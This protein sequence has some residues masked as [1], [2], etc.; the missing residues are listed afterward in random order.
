MNEITVDE[1]AAP[2]S[3][4]L[5]HAQAGERVTITREGRPVACL[6]PLEPSSPREHVSEAVRA[7]RKLR[8]GNR[9]GRLSFR[10]L[11]EE[12]RR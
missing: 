1:A 8:Q 4:L 7:L 3:G 6:V 5:D 10:D 12:G 11:I 2:L 9:L